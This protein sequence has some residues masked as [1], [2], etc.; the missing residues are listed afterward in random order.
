MT[1]TM[2]AAVLHGQEDV[3]VEDLP[4]PEPGPG[5]ILLRN[6]AALTCG[7]DVKVFLSGYHARMLRPP[8]VFGHEVAGV[9]EAVGEGVRGLAPGQRVV[10]ANSAP[11]QTCRFCAR[12]RFNL[13]DDLL[14]WNGAYAQFSC[15]PARIVKSNVLVLPDQLSF[16]EAALVEPL[17][18]V[19]RGVEDSAIEDDQNVAVL[20]TGSI[21]LMFVVLSRLRGASVLAVGRNASRRRRA[22]GLGATAFDAGDGRDLGRR[23]REASPGGRGFDVVIE[24]AGQAATVEAAFEAVA[25]GGLVNLFAGSATGTRVPLDVS[26]AHYEELRVVASFHHTPGAIREAHRL[27][28][29]GLV[30]AG[31]FVTGEAPLDELPAVLAASARGGDGGKTAILPWPTPAMEAPAKSEGRS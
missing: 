17:A 27:L 3:R 18:C 9:V 30:E 20:G 21:G 31:A 14:F 4:V 1:A 26:R 12:G 19:V 10:V 8:T 6:Q 25:K 16:R 24:A 22:E 2:R 15:I 5:E 28:A 29:H 23:L 13:C 7:T 11:C